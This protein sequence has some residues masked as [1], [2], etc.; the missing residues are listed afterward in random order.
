[1]LFVTT[2]GNQKSHQSILLKD[3]CCVADSRLDQSAKISAPSTQHLV[4]QLTI[5]YTN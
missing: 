2:V 3:I 4:H 1:M 5:L